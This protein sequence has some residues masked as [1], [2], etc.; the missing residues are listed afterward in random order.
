MSQGL[1]MGLAK[2]GE[3]IFILAFYKRLPVRDLY[4]YIYVLVCTLLL[5]ALRHTVVPWHTIK[6]SP[7]L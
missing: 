5:S 7:I 3:N 6:N 1:A 4:K 2:K